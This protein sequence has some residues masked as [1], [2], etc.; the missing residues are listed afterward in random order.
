MLGCHSCGATPSRQSDL[1]KTIAQLLIFMRT[2]DAAS[3]ESSAA[4]MAVAATAPASLNHL[5]QA[6]RMFDLGGDW[7]SVHRQVSK[8]QREALDLLRDHMGAATAV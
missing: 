8:E 3:L 5:H 4:V 2:A 1:A 7:P 6:C